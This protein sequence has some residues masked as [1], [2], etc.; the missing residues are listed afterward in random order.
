[1]TTTIRENVT[2]AAGIAFVAA[3]AIHLFKSINL[4]KKHT[5]ELDDNIK[6]L[7]ALE[8]VNE[9]CEQQWMA[10]AYKDEIEWEND[11][12]RRLEIELGHI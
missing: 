9:F 7:D 8:R 10:G 3:S 5:Q 4:T 11:F 2:L 12:N 6:Y 1:M